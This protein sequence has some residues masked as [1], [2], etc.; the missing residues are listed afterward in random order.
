MSVVL[1]RPTATIYREEQNFAWW[2]YGLMILLLVLGLG[3]L[4]SQRENLKEAVPA[5]RN[6]RSLEIPLYVLLGVGLPTV[7]VVSVLHLTTEVAPGVVRIWFGFFP[8]YRR[9]LVLSQIVRVEIV[10][11]DAIREHGFWGARRTRDGEYVFT[12]RGNRAVRLI[13]ND[14]G[15][16]LIGSQR[17]EELAA[18]LDRERRVAA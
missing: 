2:V 1:A 6:L 7:M 15:R 9:S 3:A 12:A 17:P 16:V 5:V 18:T 10:E 14:G 4:R 11:Y 13:M 8:T